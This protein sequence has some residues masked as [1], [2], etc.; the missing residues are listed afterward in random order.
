[1]GP[2]LRHIQ[3][4]SGT[5][6]GIQ[7]DSSR[8]RHRIRHS[9]TGTVSSG[10][11]GFGDSPHDDARGHTAEGQVLAYTHTHTMHTL[12]KVYSV[13]CCTPVLFWCGL[14]NTVSCFPTYPR[15]GCSGVCR[16]Y[17]RCWL[18]A[19]FNVPVYHCYHCHCSSVLPY[20][21]GDDVFFTHTHTERTSLE[22]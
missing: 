11:S 21:V 22:V 13:C 17:S 18:T 15:S 6:P 3:A 19:W 4:H 8:F 16:L 5:D 20:C 2:S 14:A 9:G 10:F 1:V 7:A 12:R